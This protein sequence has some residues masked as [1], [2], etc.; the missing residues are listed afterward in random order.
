M[1]HHQQ[2]GDNWT[3]VQI[4][5]VST[6]LFLR[7]NYIGTCYTISMGCH[8]DERN[9]EALL[10]CYFWHKKRPVVWKLALLLEMLIF[11]LILR[12][13]WYVCMDEVFWNR[14][15][16]PD[17]RVLN[18]FHLNYELWVTGGINLHLSWIIYQQLNTLW[19]LITLKLWVNN[20]KYFGT[21]LSLVWKKQFLT[22]VW[23]HCNRT[24]QVRNKQ[25][26]SFR[27][28]DISIRSS[29]IF[30]K[31]LELYETQRTYIFK[32][33]AYIIPVMV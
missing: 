28:N 30:S 7:F 14:I 9:H 29:I 3:I 15:L 17:W 4:V 5:S 24:T 21:K 6:C 23:F 18:L 8:F 11:F 25:T 33:A 10:Y 27:Q 26:S 20:R 16:K 31:S 32:A 2:T 19:D 1:I 22:H 13:H 12:R